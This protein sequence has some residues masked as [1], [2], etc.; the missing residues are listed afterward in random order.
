M[1]SSSNFFIII[2]S[3]IFNLK[4]SNNIDHCS[5]IVIVCITKELCYGLQIKLVAVLCGKA[6]LTTQDS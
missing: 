6:Q 1:C 3:F 5:L 4:P 2:L